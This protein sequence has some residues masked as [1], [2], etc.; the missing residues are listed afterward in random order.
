MTRRLPGCRKPNNLPRYA[1]R[2]EVQSCPDYFCYGCGRRVNEMVN[3]RVWRGLI[4]ENIK[5]CV[6][7]KE[8]RNQ[9]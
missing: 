7:C 8:R 3:V 9:R 4:P 2:P 6:D 5:R 1:P